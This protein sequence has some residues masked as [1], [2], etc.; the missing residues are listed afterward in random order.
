MAEDGMGGAIDEGTGRLKER[1]SSPEEE[2]ALAMETLG[3]AGV[4]GMGPE[5]S[6]SSPALR[7]RVIFLSS[8]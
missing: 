8:L 4:A 6:Q 2:E 7:Q 5:V 1:F 3:T